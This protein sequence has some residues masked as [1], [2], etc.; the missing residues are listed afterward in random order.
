M[1]LTIPSHDFWQ[2]AWIFSNEEGRVS[3]PLE[4][5]KVLHEQEL[6]RR[7]VKPSYYCEI[8]DAGRKLLLD[9]QPEVLNMKFDQ[10]YPTEVKPYTEI[11]KISG[12][13]RNLIWSHLGV[14][15]PKQHLAFF[16]YLGYLD[17]KTLTARGKALIT[18]MLLKDPQQL[19]EIED[20]YI[21]SREE[22]LR[23]TPRFLQMLADCVPDDHW[24][25]LLANL[26]PETA[27]NFAK[28]KRQE[29][30]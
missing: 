26:E 18:W 20:R 9:L 22:A 6:V 8:T 27:T 10:L 25:I 15:L 17:E 1:Q 11:T 29:I 7:L 2:L 14:D 3:D 12:K 30:S 23:L 24:A 13:I 28:I 19:V 4:E 21:P 16:R 5:H